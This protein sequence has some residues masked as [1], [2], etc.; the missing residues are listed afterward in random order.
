[1]N[2]DRRFFLRSLAAGS[3]ALPGLLSEL[4]AEDST[5]ARADGD[6]GADPLAPRRGHHPPRARSAIFLFMTGGVSHL[7]S[8][9]YKPVLARDAGKKFRG[10]TLVG[11]QFKFARYGR[12]GLEVSELFP[13]IARHADDLCVVRSLH[14][15]HFEHFQ[16]TTGIHTGSVTV[17]RPSMGSWVSYG[18]GTENRNLPSFVVL[19]PFLPY[20]GSQAWSSD[21]LPVCHQ[22][23]RIIPGEDPVTDLKRRGP[24]ETVQRMELDLLDRFNLKHLEGR[25]GDPHLAG[26]IRAFETA[27]GMQQAMPEALDLSRETDATLAL[28]GLERGSMKGFAWQCLVARRLVERGVRFVELIESGSSNNWDSHGDMKEHLPRA[29]NVDQAIAGLITDLKSRG[30]LEETLVVFTTEFGRTPHADGRTGRSHHPY[31]FSS[32]LAGGGVKGG[33]A[34]GGSDDYGYEPAEKP[35]HLHDF[36]ATILHLLGIDHERLTYRHGGRDFRLTDVY[37]RVVRDILL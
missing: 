8:F 12:S 33:I 4:L 26:R 27:F 10:R 20:A 2:P 28:Y 24:S 9:D 1:M 5:D 34:Y 6:R 15:T 16:A 30:L 11:P 18:L 36:H 3:L 37:G 25:R 19:A 17:K 32:W 35:V 31:V 13:N 22:G 23:I 29:R 14:G 21:F 7:E